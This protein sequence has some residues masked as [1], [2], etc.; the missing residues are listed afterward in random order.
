MIRSRIGQALCSEVYAA[1]MQI[2]EAAGGVPETGVEPCRFPKLEE[3]AHFHYERVQLPPLVV[4]LQTN[5]DQSLHSQ[6]T[7]NDK[8]E[9]YYMVQ[10]TSGEECWLLQRNIDNFKMLDA[11]LH[12]CIYDRKISQLPDLSSR[13]TQCDGECDDIELTLKL[14]LDKLCGIVNNSLNCGPVLNWLQMDNKGHRLLVP[15]EESRSINTPAVAAAYSIRRYVSQARDELNLEVGDMI[16]VIDMASPGESIWWRGKRGFQVGFFPQHCVHII[17]D[18][19]PR[20]MPLPPPVVGSLALS[21][22]KPV[23][24]KHGKLIAFFRSFILNRPSRRRLKQTGIL[25]ERVFGCDLGEHLLNSGHDIPTVLKCCAEFIE[26]NGIVDGIYRLSGVTS[27]IQKL[28]NAFDEDRIPN[29]Y[30][31]EI[32]QDIHSVASLL[33]MY[34]RELPNPLCTYQLYQSFVNAVQGCNPSSRNS[35][36]DRERLLKMR[37]AVQK[38]P[39]PHYRTLEYLMRHLA[40]VARHGARTG[41]TTRNVAIVWAPNLLRSEE[42]EGGGVAALQGV[43]VQAVVTEFLICYTDLIFCDHL[44]RVLDGD[45]PV[46]NVVAVDRSIPSPKRSRPKS[47]AISTPTKL[48]TLEEARN[49]HQQVTKGGG[50]ESGYIEVGGGPKNLPKKYHTVLELPPPSSSRKRHSSGWRSFFSKSRSSPPQNSL[51]KNRK[52]STPGG[53]VTTTEKCMAAAAAAVAAA[54]TELNLAEMKRKLRTVKSAE[55]LTSGISE[56]VNNNEID[57]LGPLHSLH[58]PPGHNRSVSHDSYFDTIQ[59][60]QNNSEGSLLDLSEIQLN[61]ELE[62]SEMR[63]FSEDESLVSSPRIQKDGYRRYL[64]RARPDDYHLGTVGDSANPS[65]KK[66]ARA[67]LTSPPESSTSRKRTRLEDQLSDIQYIDCNTPDNLVVTVSTTAQI[68]HAPAIAAAAAADSTTATAAVEGESYR[69]PKSKS[70]RNSSSNRTEGVISPL[71]IGEKLLLLVQ[72]G[73]LS[74]P[75]PQSPAY[76]PLNDSSARTTPGDSGFPF[77]TELYLRTTHL[78][79]QRTEHGEGAGNANRKANST[80]SIYENLVQSSSSSS[81]SSPSP[82]KTLSPTYE[83]VLTTISITYRSPTKRF[84]SNSSPSAIN[85]G[86]DS[87]YEDI[88]T[89]MERAAKVPTEPAVLP[90]QEANQPNEMTKDGGRRP[91]SLSALEELRAKTEGVRLK[92]DSSTSAVCNSRSE[93]RTISNNGTSSLAKS[94]ETT[95]TFDS[96]ASSDFFANASSDA[97]SPSAAAR[98]A[99]PPPYDGVVSPTDDLSLSEI[100]AH[101]YSENLSAEQYSCPATPTQTS[102]SPNVSPTHDNTNDSRTRN[103]E[104]DGSPAAAATTT[105]TRMGSKTTV[106]K[107]AMEAVVADGNRKS[108]DASTV[109]SDDDDD[110]GDGGGGG[111]VSSTNENEFRMDKRKSSETADEDDYYNSIY[112]QVK[113]LRR[114]VHEINAL[115]MD[116]GNNIDGNG[117]GGRKTEKLEPMLVPQ[118]FDSLEEEAVK[119]DDRHL[120]ENIDDDDDRHRRLSNSDD[121]AEGRGVAADAENTERRYRH[122]HQRRRRQEDDANACENVDVKS[123]TNIFEHRDNNAVSQSKT[124]P[125]MSSPTTVSQ[126]EEITLSSPTM[127]TRNSNSFTE[128]ICNLVE[129]KSRQQTTTTSTSERSK[130][131]LYDKDSLPPCVRLRNLRY[132]NFKTRS[133]DEHEFSKECGGGDDELVAPSAHRTQLRTTPTVPSSSAAAADSSRRK[134]LDENL[135]SAAGYRRCHLP[136]IATNDPKPL[137]RPKPLPG[138]ISAVVATGENDDRQHHRTM[139]A[140]HRQRDDRTEGVAATS[141]A[142]AVTRITSALSDDTKLNRERIERYKEERRRELHEKYRSESFKENRGPPPPLSRLKPKSKEEEEDADDDE[143]TQPRRD[144]SEDVL[145]TTTYSRRARKKSDASVEEGREGGGDSNS[146][147][148]GDSLEMEI[149]HGGPI[150]TGMTTTTARRA[151]SDDVRL[152]TIG[153]K[154][155]RRINKKEDGDTGRGGGEGGTSVVRGDVDDKKQQQQGTPKTIR[156]SV[157]APAAA[158]EEDVRRR[159]R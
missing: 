77:G 35:D 67:A 80:T 29:L 33:K 22:I 85:A 48:I 16:S 19:V 137:N 8:D 69:P 3:C 102:L 42:L 148:S 140:Q 92:S 44:P 68:H 18:K 158:V 142:A 81:S 108:S 101:T 23:L 91:K 59:N 135:S 96:S 10:V 130:K 5:M 14:Y 112:Q 121:K 114:S 127:R 139:V 72:A 110:G 123:L 104:S 1:D 71:D 78:D 128:K 39:P 9:E 49:K 97:S 57:G 30:T 75:T 90:T 152:K 86:V 43:G 131:N 60:S 38:L 113:Y 116:V 145:P 88:S 109:T 146:E 74:T 83:N 143:S 111:A 27:N 150:T 7:T 20:N 94:T 53:S 13:S 63:I 51:A 66:Q 65:P 56:A 25:K 147:M 132:A 45:V 134:S 151:V 115:V 103:T 64:A 46:N 28:R 118:H 99:A 100:V 50:D 58:K 133:L 4:T 31:E 87:I 79:R 156:R 26:Q 54:A 24:R 95:A 12:Q 157:G 119:E 11:Q 37:E 21:P 138:A 52:A 73:A 107:T 159:R 34:F 62:E 154:L 76:R 47:L 15:S 82:P 106:R 122:H 125:S 93:T 155:D 17:G 98:A 36:T 144:R 40:K 89:D 70:P 84:S 105:T 117:D 136:P 129:E 61:F 126:H 41:M 149:G 32:L 55:S 141:A 124:S 120:Y 6:H 2:S 153:G